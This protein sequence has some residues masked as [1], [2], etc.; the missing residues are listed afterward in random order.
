[1]KL[2]AYGKKLEVLWE[3][4][5]WVIYELGDGKKRRSNDLYIPSE[6][7][8]DEVIGFLEDMLH[9]SATP[10]NPAIEIIEWKSAREISYLTKLSMKFKKF[11]TA[12]TDAIASAA[13]A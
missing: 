2:N 12:F 8:P 5:A 13:E 3:D 7:S 10:E 4:E 1:M 9:E 11:L 6:Y